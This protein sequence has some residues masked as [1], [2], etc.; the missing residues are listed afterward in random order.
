MESKSKIV[1]ELSSTYAAR[2]MTADD[3][4]IIYELSLG[5]ALFYQYC[6]PFV[7]KESIEEDMKALPPGMSYDD[8]FYVGFFKESKLIA[9]MDFVF[10]YPNE[11]TVFIGLFMVDKSEQGKGVGS[12]IIDEC[13]HCVRK[14]G[15]RFLRLAY[16]KGNPQSEAF[17][18]KNGFE[19]TG[20]ESN[21]GSY[22]AVVLQKEI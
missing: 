4:N 7:T 10:N 9:V 11:E 22:T 3:V 20:M 2:I 19:S 16:A 12:Q 18:K 14:K 8:K 17:W 13:S 1:F 5:N 6:P 21:K 15:Y